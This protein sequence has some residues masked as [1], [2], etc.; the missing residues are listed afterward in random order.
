MWKTVHWSITSMLPMVYSPV[1]LFEELYS[2]SSL[3]CALP[4]GGEGPG[5]GG[6]FFHSETFLNIGS[7]PPDTPNPYVEQLPERSAPSGG[8]QAS[9]SSLTTLAISC[10]VP[11]SA[12]REDRASV[13]EAG[14]FRARIGRR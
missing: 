1:Q 12:G 2:R 13:S 5:G 8:L 4:G 10:C 7:N 6:D 3:A 11:W 9:G 14:A